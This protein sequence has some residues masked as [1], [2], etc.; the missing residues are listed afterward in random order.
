MALVHYENWGM[1]NTLADAVYKGYSVLPEPDMDGL[2]YAASGLPPYLDSQNAKNGLGKSLGVPLRVVSIR[3]AADPDNSNA[4]SVN[5]GTGVIIPHATQAANATWIFSGWFRVDN[6]GASTV[7]LSLGDTSRTSLVVRLHTDGHLYFYGARGAL[8]DS[9]FVN[10]GY[11]LAN[12]N[13]VMS[14]F[15]ETAGLTAYGNTSGLPYAPLVARRWHFLEIKF[16][17]SGVTGL[18]QARI[19]GAP[20]MSAFNVNT[21][22][23]GT[24]T[25]TNRTMVSNYLW[26]RD[27]GNGAT[28][29][30]Y[31]GGAP[32]SAGTAVATYWDGMFITDET[33]EELNDYIG[34]ATLYSLAP[35]S[36]NVN[37]VN[38]NAFDVEGAASAHLAV[39]TL[40]GEASF[41]NA[42]PDATIEF[43]YANLPN[44]VDDEAIRAVIL[45]SFARGTGNTPKTLQH[46]YAGLPTGDATTL[47]PFFNLKQDFMPVNPS[48]GNPWT[49]NEVNALN[50]RTLVRDAAE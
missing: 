9:L 39:A 48:T 4:I 43:G 5:Q 32:F 23:G 21:N 35:T 6:F 37:G 24:I 15:D 12:D 38:D 33:G 8:R 36:T 26:T 40:D 10:T 49:I 47:D 44:D 1:F 29:P 46:T 11:T 17:L 30:N 18:V 19:D 13:R 45:A 31:G 50:P 34:P 22:G 16:R 20:V 2:L 7:I 27:Y 14:F 41:I 28:S 3:P 25:S 42:T